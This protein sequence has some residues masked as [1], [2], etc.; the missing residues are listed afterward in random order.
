MKFVAKDVQIEIMS[1]DDF[2]RRADAKI[3]QIKE[4]KTAEFEGK[5][6]VF[7]SLDILRK[8]LTPK[9]IQMLRVIRANNPSSIYELAKLLKKDRRNVLKDLRYLEGTG[10]IEVKKDSK[11][12]SERRNLIPTVSFSRIVVGIPI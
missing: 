7:P 8:V 1:L 12:K 4:G 9:R 2:A 6:L 10:L 11:P 3:K 5:K